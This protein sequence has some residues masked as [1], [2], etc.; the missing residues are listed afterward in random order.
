M[1]IRNCNP[2]LQCPVMSKED[3]RMVSQTVKT[4]FEENDRFMP[5]SANGGKRK[6]T[7]SRKDL[8]YA[9]ALLLV[10]LACSDENFADEERNAIVTGLQRIFGTPPY[11]VVTLIARARTTIASF[12][13]T[14]DFAHLL[15]EN[16]TQDQLKGIMAVV[17]N[18]VQAD[19]KADGF[20]MYHR[21]KF[22]R[23]LG[24]AIEPPLPGSR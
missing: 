9:L 24:L 7:P 21:H 19:G 14:T 23:L 11:E 8:E 1:Y 2:L 10:E 20:E 18:V 17:D 13:S 6:V 3:F 5:P 15:K 16:L 22:A 4:I 12:R